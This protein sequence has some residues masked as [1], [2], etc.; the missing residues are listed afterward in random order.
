MFPEAC[1]SLLNFY[2]P[3]KCKAILLGVLT[4]RPVIFSCYL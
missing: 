4:V 1:N 3:A 2:V